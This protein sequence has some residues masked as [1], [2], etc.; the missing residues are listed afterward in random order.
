MRFILALLTLYRL[1][2]LIV[3]EDGPFLL[4]IRW[5]TW[6]CRQQEGWGCDGVTCVWCASFW[7]A[8]PIALLLPRNSRQEYVLNALGL[9]G[10][11]LLLHSTHERIARQ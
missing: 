1:A 8:W 10:A 5:R 2:H 11:A 6:V 4:A 3:L 9:A 7:L